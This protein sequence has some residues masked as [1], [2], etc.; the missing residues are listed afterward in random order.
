MVDITPGSAVLRHVTWSRGTSPNVMNIQ[1]GC[2]L[3]T[4]APRSSLV[5]SDI[6]DVLPLESA[7]ST[8][9]LMSSDPA[10]VALQQVRSIE[11]L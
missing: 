4:D 7:P 8:T 10:F 1:P 11:S 6:G 3:Y 5:V 9:F 2:T